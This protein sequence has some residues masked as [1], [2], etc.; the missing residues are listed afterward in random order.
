M[1][2]RLQ[3]MYENEN[4]VIY[5]RLFNERGV[6]K[7]FCILKNSGLVVAE[8]RSITQAKKYFVGNK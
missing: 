4:I 6:K 2:Y 3:R 5:H 1:N 8:F 7:Y